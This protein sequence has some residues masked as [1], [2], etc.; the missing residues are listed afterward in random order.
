[1]KRNEVVKIL[2]YYISN[3]S[4]VA[5]CAKDVEAFEEAIRCVELRDELVNML[6]KAMKFIDVCDDT[7]FCWDRACDLLEKAKGGVSDGEG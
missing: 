5:E 6:K 2:K 4:D 1:M 7:G 3:I